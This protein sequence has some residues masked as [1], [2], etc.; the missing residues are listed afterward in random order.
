VTLH[1]P[2]P[3]C[4]SSSSRWIC[5]GGFLVLPLLLFQHP[6]ATNPPHHLLLACLPLAPT[7]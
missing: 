3:P 4:P 1:T 2:A 7:L 5:L 6:Q